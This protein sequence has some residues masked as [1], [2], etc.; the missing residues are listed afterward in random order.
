MKSILMKC[1]SS[2]AAS[3]TVWYVFQLALVNVRLL[4]PDTVRSESPD[5]RATATP[6]SLGG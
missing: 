1:A 4:P 6:T 2:A 3:V 5:W